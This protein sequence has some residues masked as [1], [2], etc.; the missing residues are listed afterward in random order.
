MGRIADRIMELLYLNGVR[1]V[2]MVTG[3]GSITLTDALKNHGQLKYICNHHE[4]ASAMAAVGYA[5]ASRELGCAIVTTGCGGTNSLTG[6]LHA[7]QDGV[8][9]IFIS[10]QVA[11]NDTIKYANPDGRQ[12]GMQE[13]DI[14]SIV[15]PITKYAVMLSS[16]YNIDEVITNAIK[17]ATTGRKGPVWIDIPANIQKAPYLSALYDL[18]SLTKYKRP[19]IVAG[20]GVWMSKSEDMVKRFAENNNIPIV[21]TRLGLNNIEYDNPLH[22]GEIGIKG[23]RAGNLAV[24][25]ADV[26]LVLGSRLA[27]ASIGYDPSLFAR[28]AH[29]IIVDLDV[30][31]HR[32]WDNYTFI[33]AELNQ[34]ISHHVNF[35]TTDPSVKEWADQCLKWKLT[36][37]VYQNEYAEWKQGIH[38]YYLVEMISKTLPPNGVV[39][40]D[41]GSAVFIATQG[42]KL[43]KGQIYV[44]AGSQGE[45]GFGLPAAIGAATIK[46][47]MVVVLTGD[48][49]LQMNLQ[50]LQT[51]KHNRLPVKIIVINNEGYLSIKTTQEKTFNGNYIGV[52][53][54]TGVSF[55]SLDKIANAYDL[56]YHSCLI[57]SHL[58][59]TLAELFSDD[60]PGICEIY[61]R[62]AQEV[63]P[64]VSARDGK[65]RPMED[66]YPFLEEKEYLD[67]LYIAS[68]RR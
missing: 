39:I 23:T 35:K 49:S 4:Q 22:I 54:D 50:E 6:V 11:I 53:S 46:N 34:W 68:I 32:A 16:P 33:H 58:E 9:C 30:N 10:G 26:L 14:V 48:G 5:Q 52:D 17:I 40:T 8:P 63:A 41:A 1:T 3:G 67:N 66:M 24:Q 51:I 57:S 45:M 18:P 27:R 60:K 42:L 21:F 61:C 37:P 7:Y 12:V 20:N 25:N 29:K 65:L 36:Y 28:E 55:P 56:P 13:A 31:E 43:K 15:K 38:M 59:D 64:S 19:V 44:T 2:F 62:G 47:K